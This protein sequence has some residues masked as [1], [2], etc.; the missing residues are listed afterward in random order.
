MTKWILKIL[1]FIMFL[2]AVGFV[3]NKNKHLYIMEEKMLEI[4]IN[5]QD[6]TSIELKLLNQFTKNGYYEKQ[7]EQSTITNI[8]L[9]RFN[10]LIASNQIILARNANF[11]NINDCHNIK[12]LSQNGKYEYI[13]KVEKD[14]NGN[15]VFKGFVTEPINK[16]TYNYF[17]QEGNFFQ[18]SL[19]HMDVML[20]FLYGTSYEDFSSFSDRLSF[21]FIRENG[22]GG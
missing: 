14:E 11:H 13:I 18:R 4:I 6:T 21:Y 15:S 8:S 22:C 1:L 5:A 17:N 20:W 10:D 12:Y 9:E 16:G 19:H 2:M 7:N 3:G